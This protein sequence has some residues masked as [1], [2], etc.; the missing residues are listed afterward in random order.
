MTFGTVINSSADGRLEVASELVCL[1]TSCQST[2]VFVV[3]G[4]ALKSMCRLDGSTTQIVCFKLGHDIARCSTCTVPAGA[5]RTS[6]WLLCRISASTSKLCFGGM[7]MG[8][9][10]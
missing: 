7:R 9:K 2:A 5:M 8:V 1:M 6:A 10:P 4:D 3:L